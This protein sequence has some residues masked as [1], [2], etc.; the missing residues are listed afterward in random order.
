VSNVKNA[1]AG[2]CFWD[3]K[4]TPSTFLFLWGQTAEKPPK[5]INKIWEI[6]VCA[7]DQHIFSSEHQK[8]GSAAQ[9]CDWGQLLSHNAIRTFTASS[10]CN[11]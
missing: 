4:L 11:K 6:F 10:L 7:G 3:Y 5:S 1:N 8:Y 2:F 9:I